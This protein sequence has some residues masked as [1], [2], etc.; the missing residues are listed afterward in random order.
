MF[1]VFTKEREIKQ[2]ARCS[3]CEWKVTIDEVGPEAGQAIAALNAHVRST[4]HTVVRR[5]SSKTIYA[6]QLED[7]PPPE[8]RKKKEPPVRTAWCKECNCQIG[9]KARGIVVFWAAGSH[10]KKSGH[11]VEIVEADGTR[12]PL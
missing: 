6:G 9:A 5:Y 8:A 10:R 1:K 12:R 2:V 7:D 4:G 11:E 3:D